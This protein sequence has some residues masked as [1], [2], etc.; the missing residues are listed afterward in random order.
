MSG[1]ED[2]GM[3]YIKNGYAIF[4]C[5]VCQKRVHK[6]D[7]KRKLILEGKIIYLCSE[8]QGLFDLLI[9]AV[10]YMKRVCA[11]S[12]KYAK[13]AAEEYEEGME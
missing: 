1:A 11:A 2:K 10:E 7:A 3:V 4:F 13:K 12:N 5:E 8:H 9:Y 6:E